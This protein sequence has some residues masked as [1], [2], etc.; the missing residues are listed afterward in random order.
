MQ[1]TKEK[2]RKKKSESE[3]ARGGGEKRENAILIPVQKYQPTHLS[4]SA[5][6]ITTDRLILR[7]LIDDDCDAMHDMDSHPLLIEATGEHI[8]SDKS[9]T[10]KHIRN[11]RKQYEANGFGRYA[12]IL[13]DT[14]EFLG[15]AGLKLEKNVN[16]HE[17]FIDLGYRLLPRFWGKGYATEAGRAL[18]SYGFEVLKVDRIC[19]YVESNNHASRRVAEQCGLRVTGGF[20]GERMREWWLELDKSEYSSAMKP[21][22]VVFC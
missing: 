6:H 18:V 21:N 11:I 2:R 3:R 1:K 14:E 16:G 7:D 22:C 8:P 13:K 4:M 9:E 17:T 12:V 15:W 20:E 5:V 19:A 10:L